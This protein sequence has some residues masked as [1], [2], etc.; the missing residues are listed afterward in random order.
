MPWAEEIAAADEGHALQTIRV[1]TGLIVLKLRGGCS[2]FEKQPGDGEDE[3]SS[4]LAKYRL[5][6][7]GHITL[8]DTGLGMSSIDLDLG[9]DSSLINHRWPHAGK[10]V[11]RPPRMRRHR[12]DP[13]MSK[14]PTLSSASSEH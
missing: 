7:A 3:D 1:C 14:L 10:Q 12:A 8:P 2:G 4:C 11:A 9:V 13:L 6:K 5:R